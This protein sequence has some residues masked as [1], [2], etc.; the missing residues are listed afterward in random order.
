MTT[1]TVCT[2]AKD[3]TAQRIVAAPQAA[4]ASEWNECGGWSAV[5][6]EPRKACFLR[7]QKCAQN[8]NSK[9]AR[10][11]TVTKAKSVDKVIEELKAREIKNQDSSLIKIESFLCDLEK[12]LSKEGEN[13]LSKQKKT[14]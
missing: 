8:K 6:A 14:I 12:K 13:T 11:E 4:T 10:I 1:S 7:K 9:I 2:D 3:K 5:S